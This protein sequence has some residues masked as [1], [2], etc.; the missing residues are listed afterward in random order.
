MREL[1]INRIE[2]IKINNRG[3]KKDSFKWRSMHCNSIHISEIDFNNL[4][5]EKLMS[6]YES[7]IIKHFS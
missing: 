5:D 7:I 2:E 6:I 1:I 4:S 3:F